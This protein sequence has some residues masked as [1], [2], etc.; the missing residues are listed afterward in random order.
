MTTDS[1]AVAELSP[2]ARAEQALSYEATKAKLETL[3]SS[4]L[5]LKRVDDDD[6][7]AAAKAAKAKLAST[8]VSIE[9]TGKAARD[10]A[11]K[12]SKAVIAKERELID[13]IRPEEDRIG[14]LIAAEETRR[15]DAERAIREEEERRAE[16]IRMAFSR[17][18]QLPQLGENAGVTAIDKLITEA[19]AFRENPGDLPQD[20]LAA[21]KYEANVA[22]ASLR[23][24]RDRRVQA[25]IDAAELEQLRAEKAE[26]DAAQAKA[27]A[28]QAKAEAAAAVASDSAGEVDQAPSLSREPAPV[29]DAPRGAIN[30]RSAPVAAATLAM[31]M[32][33]LLSASKAAHALLLELG[34]AGHPVVVDLESAID[35]ADLPGAF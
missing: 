18:R 32:L 20:M 7:L 34:H 19:E 24:S 16:A 6:S 21:A 28:A 27:D 14:A 5:T 3:A 31:P 2:E 23:A 8:R 4:W 29:A 11:T 22:I 13:V 33:S 9:K 17:V 35:D 1:K 30:Q 10:S 25:D 12:Y 15:A 26:R